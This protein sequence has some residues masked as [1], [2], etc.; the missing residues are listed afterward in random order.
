M[1]TTA[2]QRGPRLSVEELKRAAAEMRAIDIVDIFAAGSGHPGGTLSIMD[3]AAALYLR[4]LNHDP[5]DPKWPERDRVYWSAGHK[6]PALYVSLGKAGYFPLEDTVLL[7]QLGSGFEGHPNRLKVPGV[8]ISSGSLGQGLGAAVGNALAAKLLGKLYRV[9]CFM[10]D[11]EQQEGSIWEAAMAG[12]HYQLDNLCGVI[13]QNGLQIDGQVKEVMNVESLAAKYTAFGWNVVEID[14]HNMEQIVAGYEKAQTMKGKPT[15]LIARTV[16]GKGVPFM[17]N[18]AGWHGVAPNKEQFEKAIPN[19]LS[20]DVPRERVDGLVARASDNAKRVAKET[21]AAIPQ[22]HKDRWW[23]ALPNMK[24]DMDPTR[25]GFGRGL[26]S[27]GED[28]RVVTIH[29]DI[30]NSIRITDFEAKHPE[31]KNRVFSVGIAEQNMMSVAAGLSAAG[32][33]P[34][35]GT[36]GVFASGRAWDQIRTTICYSNLNVKIAGAHGGISVGPDGA[37]HQSL[38]EISLMSILPNMHVYVPCDSVETEK[39]TKHALLELDGPAYLRFAR[40]ATPIVSTKDTPYVFGAANVIRYRGEKEKFL[41][42]FETCLASEYKNE[43]ED[44]SIIACGPMV[45]EAMRAAWMLKEEYG[46]E[47]RVVN[48]HTVK[49]LDVAALLAAATDTRC[50]VTAEEH[51]VGG[52]GNIIAGAILKHRGA[53]EHALQFDMVGVKDRFGLSGKPWELVQAFGL[54]AEHVADRVKKLIERKHAGIEGTL[55]HTTVLAAVECSRCRA[56]VP[57][58]EFMCETPLAGEEICAEC[59]RRSEATCAECRTNWTLT[60]PN[61][62]YLCRDCRDIAV[63]C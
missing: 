5:S 24:V 56:L 8:E 20:N 53:H 19:L 52:F 7:R 41:D 50:I 9:Y 51:Q 48:V 26:D 44:A 29:A 10:G 12:G 58:G 11:G 34:V 62:N 36:Y 15:V 18:E 39:A 28:P 1:K 32:L 38:E 3:L 40:E 16:K 31:R 25:M 42:A 30:S 46:I 23:N 17:E 21:K 13:D 59:E 45:P 47:V 33:I 55:V 35:T 6:A 57:F 49:P 54:T 43:N 22:F 63:Q 61:F 4:V 27:A 2:E 14:G 37:T 60:N